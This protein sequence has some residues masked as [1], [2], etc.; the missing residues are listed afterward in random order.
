M[1]IILAFGGLIPFPTGNRRNNRGYSSAYLDR[2]LADA[3]DFCWMS[4]AGYPYP[5]V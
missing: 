4:A 5:A 1:L 2:S 3:S